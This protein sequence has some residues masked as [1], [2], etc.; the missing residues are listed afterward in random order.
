MGTPAE[1]AEVLLELFRKERKLPD[2][3][4]RISV[5]QMRAMALDLTVHFARSEGQLPEPLIELLAMLLGLPEEFLGDTRPF[6]ISEAVGGRPSADP[7]ARNLAQWIDAT[8]AN[9]RLP[10]MSVSAM[11]KEIQRRLGSEKSI[12]RSTIRR[13]RLEADYVEFVEFIREHGGETEV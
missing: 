10:V 13:W 2:S 9:A 8:H 12:A 6:F 4:S 5:G 7:A 1:R 3:Q 11:E